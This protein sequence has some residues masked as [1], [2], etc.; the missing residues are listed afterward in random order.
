MLGP[1]DIAQAHGEEEW[2]A[3]EQVEQSAEI[4]YLLAA[5]A[6]EL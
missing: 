3:V 4:Y 5:A 6:H 1:G 2:V